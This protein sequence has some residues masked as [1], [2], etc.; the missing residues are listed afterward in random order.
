[1]CD[2]RLFAELL[3]VP[4]DEVLTVYRSVAI[5]VSRDGKDLDPA[6]AAPLLRRL[7]LHTIQERFVMRHRYSPGD[8]VLWDNTATLHYASPI[9]PPKDAASRRLLYRI[10]ATGLPPLLRGPLAS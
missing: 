1:M 2:V 10:V 4:N 9:G 6:E 5:G 7:K 3:I 8:L